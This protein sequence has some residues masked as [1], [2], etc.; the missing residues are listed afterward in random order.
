MAA[1]CV[2]IHSFSQHCFLTKKTNAKI[3]GDVSTVKRKEAK[4]LQVL[5]SASALDG[6]A[7]L[8]TDYI[9]GTNILSLANI[10]IQSPKNVN[11]T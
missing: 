3:D 5:P 8:Q 2:F 1:F 6:T 9:N 11:C 7:D 4:T 10:G